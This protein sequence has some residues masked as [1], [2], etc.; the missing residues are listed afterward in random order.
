MGGGGVS[1]AYWETY[2]LSWGY[3]VL[4]Q[5]RHDEV[6]YSIDL[7]IAGMASHHILGG[8]ESRGILQACQPSALGN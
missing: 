6:V 3:C 7:D 1:R 8:Y 4:S 2:T 5:Y